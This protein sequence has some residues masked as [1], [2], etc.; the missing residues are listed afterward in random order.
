MP[1]NVLNLAECG[2]YV[3]SCEI[4]K[5]ALLVPNPRSRRG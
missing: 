5:S 1:S 4:E 2:R 3:V